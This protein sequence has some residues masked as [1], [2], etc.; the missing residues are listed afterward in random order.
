[1]DGLAVNGK[2]RLK[3]DKTDISDDFNELM[4]TVTDTFG[5]P[6]SYLKVYQANFLEMLIPPRSKRGN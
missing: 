5:L 1:M 2:L 6:L 4:K 3:I